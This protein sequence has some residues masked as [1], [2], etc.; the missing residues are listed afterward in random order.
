MRDVDRVEKP[1]T[2][3]QANGNSSKKAAQQNSGYQRINK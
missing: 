2:D 3:R 1:E